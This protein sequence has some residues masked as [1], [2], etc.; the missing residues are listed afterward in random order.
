MLPITIK[1]IFLTFCFPIL[2][3]GQPQG[4]ALQPQERQ[5]PES[6]HHLRSLDVKIVENN[7]SGTYLFKLNGCT[8]HHVDKDFYSQYKNDE[9]SWPTFDEAN[10]SDKTEW[11]VVSHYSFVLEYI[12]SDQKSLFHAVHR[13]EGGGIGANFTTGED[14]IGYRVYDRA[15]TLLGGEYF[16]SPQEPEAT[17]ESIPE[18]RFRLHVSGLSNGVMVQWSLDHGK[19]WSDRVV[20]PLGLPDYATTKIPI[21][22]L[23]K[24]QEIQLEFDI[25]VGMKLFRKRF[26]YN[27]D[28]KPLKGDFSPRPLRKQWKP[29]KENSRREDGWENIPEK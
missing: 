1:S 2:L 26:I 9:G 3:L 27:G 25:M 8:D 4:Q 17:L 24:N 18:G 11:R 21:H 12:I 28:G 16:R 19:S 13:S 14:G 5:I 6:G 29:T 23:G 10:A 22:V 20:H 7:Q 15:R